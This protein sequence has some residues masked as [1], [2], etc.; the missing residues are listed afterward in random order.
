MA[1]RGS[2]KVCSLDDVTG[3]FEI[4]QQFDAV[5]I[6]LNTIKQETNLFG[7]ESVKCMVQKFVV[8]IYAKAN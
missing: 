4:N 5:R 2:A 3:S 8:N 1:T 7:Y 6:K